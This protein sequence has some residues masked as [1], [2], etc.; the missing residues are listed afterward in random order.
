MRS[1]SKRCCSSSTWPRHSS[2]IVVGEQPGDVGAERRGERRR[3]G[4]QEVAGEDRHDVAPAGVHARHAAAGLGLVDHV[5]VVERPEVD[6]LD[7]DRA[8]DRVVRGRAVAACGGVGGAERERRA[9]A[10]CR[11]PRSGGRDLAQEAVVGADRVRRARPRP[12]RGRRRAAPARRRRPAVH[13]RP[14]YGRSR[15]HDS[16][17]EPGTICRAPSVVWISE[18]STVTLRSVDDRVT[19]GSRRQRSAETG[20]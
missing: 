10:A 9:G 8:G 20:R 11:R 13:R 16:D 5:V 17:R 18:T 1:A 19:T 14:R 15:G 7:R 2:P 6:E 12:G 3:L 4:E